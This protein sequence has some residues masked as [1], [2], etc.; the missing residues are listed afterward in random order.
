MDSGLRPNDGDGTPAHGAAIDRPGGGTLCLPA[1][2]ASATD[3]GEGEEART[4][5]GDISSWLGLAAFHLA[6]YVERTLDLATLLPYGE[7]LDALWS[8]DLAG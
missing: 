7:F 4:C 3:T 8:G 2:A 6:A 1:T 5:S